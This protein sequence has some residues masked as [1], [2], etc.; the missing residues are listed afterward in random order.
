MPKCKACKKAFTP[1]NS[2]QKACG[3]KCALELVELQKREKNK[4][5]SS[6]SVKKARKQLKKLSDN[7]KS[8]LTKKAQR[9]FNAF[10]RKRDE[11]RACISCGRTNDEANSTDGWKIGG[12]WDCGHYLT[13][14]GFPELRFEE[15]NAHKQCKTCNGCSNHYAKKSRLVSERYRERLIKKIGLDKVEWLEGPHEPKKYTI[16]ELKEIEQEYKR[17]LK[18][19]N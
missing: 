15:L 19:L 3:P 6:E 4:L 8:K 16:E 18:E 11:G 12:A 14:G 1:F 17:K 13:R 9:A 5:F 7:D 2:M 10:I